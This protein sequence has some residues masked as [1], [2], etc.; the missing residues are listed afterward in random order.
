MH[1][2]KKKSGVFRAQLG[3]IRFGEAVLGCKEKPHSAA[4][5]NLQYSI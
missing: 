4:L 2:E 1:N 5:V 3:G